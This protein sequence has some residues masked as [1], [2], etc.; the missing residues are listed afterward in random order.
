MSLSKLDLA[1]AALRDEPLPIPL[2]RRR[3]NPTPKIA[4]A[5]AALAAVVLWPR[6]DAG[7]VF[8]QSLERSAQAP[9]AHTIRRLDE[10]G[11][12]TSERWTEGPRVRQI[13]YN[14]DGTKAHEWRSDGVRAA[15]FSYFP[16]TPDGRPNPNSFRYVRLS[17][18]RRPDPAYVPT[19]LEELLRR[20]RGRVVAAQGDRFTVRTP[21]LGDLAVTTE[22]RGGRILKIRA[23]KYRPS[24]ETINY[25]ALIDPANF[26]LVPP[27][28][29]RFA[30]LDADE[31]RR[32]FD[33]RMA[34]GLGTRDGVTLRSLTLS[35]DGGVQAI[36]SEPPGGRDLFTLKGVPLRLRYAGIGRLGPGFV[37]APFGRI[38]ATLVYPSVKIGDR[39]TVRIGRRELPNVPVQRV[40]D[41][42]R[43]TA[44]LG[45]YRS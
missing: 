29:A 3:R 38:R 22:P 7:D 43:L 28:A 41:T 33:A 23:T 16:M 42:N 31:M 24:T 14:F 10:G 1:I 20:R 11:R 6:P 12:L 5:T 2:V 18:A 25:P 17:P 34:R 32:T 15:S 40:D 45:V 36:W 9:R 35:A 30:V 21:G 39:V 19:S 13:L 8:A 44:D 26:V 4:L 37:R 27:V